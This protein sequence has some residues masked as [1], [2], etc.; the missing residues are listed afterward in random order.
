MPKDILP[1]RPLAHEI[2]YSDPL[3][4]FSFFAD[5]PFAIFLD[6]AKIE[7][8]L[9]KFSFIAVDPFQT[10]TCKNGQINLNGT[11]IED[12]PFLVLK[13]QLLAFPLQS[14]VNLPSFQGG[15]AGYFAY[16]LCRHLEKIPAHKL[17]NHNFSDLMLGFYDLVIGFDHHQK[18]AW[19]FSSGYPEQD[20]SKN[21]TRAE[22]RCHFL[23]K[24]IQTAIPSPR[25]RNN[26]NNHI[27]SFSPIY[28]NYSQQDYENMVQ[29]VIDYINAGDIFQANVSQCFST[30]LSNEFCPFTLYQRLRDINPAPFAAYLNFSDTIIASASPERFLKLVDGVVE[31]RPIK[32]TNP[33]GKTPEEDEHLRQELLNSEK[34]RAENTMIVD[35][36]RND[37]SRVCCDHTVKVTQLN[38][39]ESY[40]TVHHLVSIVVGELKPNLNAIDLIQATFPGGSITGAP[41]IRAMEIIAEFEPTARG[42]YCGS[43]GYI[44]FD[45]TMDLSITIRTYTIKDNHLTFQTGGGIVSDSVPRNEYK[46]TLTKAAALLKALSG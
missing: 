7:N 35:L 27:N 19:I 23:L 31:T 24:K 28:S 12:D 38:K 3:V 26:E 21:Q 34:D 44:G 46:E 41:K 14:H 45:G 32:G 16:D 8:E 33:R 9:G 42:P 37:L 15:L 18:K 22:N 43:I 6:S 25:I 13:Q 20:P 30:Q 39:L 29:Y 4:I 5:D 2:P 10:L 1:H 17:D 40:A 36:M 11:K